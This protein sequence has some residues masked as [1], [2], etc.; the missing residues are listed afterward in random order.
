M[1]DIEKLVTGK[2]DEKV[3]FEDVKD[4]LF[5]REVEITNDTY[6]YTT[7]VENLSEQ[8]QRT[9]FTRIGAMMIDFA[10]SI[11]FLE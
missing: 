6:D 2:I 8:T 4:Y 10:K 5:E 9:I 3:L 1:I 7:N 11:E